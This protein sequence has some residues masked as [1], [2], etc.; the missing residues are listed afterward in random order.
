MQQ[1]YTFT[2]SSVEIDDSSTL[3][4]TPSDEIDDSS[5]LSPTP[6]D[7]IDDSSTLSPTQAL[8]LTTVL[9]FRKLNIQKCETVKIIT[10]NLLAGRNVTIGFLA[11]SIGKP[12]IITSTRGY[13][14]SNYQIF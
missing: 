13:K 10:L 7:E 9:H 3:S 14:K 2:D 12:L 4:P 1:F 6:S 5:T 11:F 8:K